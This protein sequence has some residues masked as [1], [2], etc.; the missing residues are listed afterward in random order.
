MSRAFRSESYHKF[1]RSLVQDKVIFNQ[2]M[3][4][5]LALH[6]FNYNH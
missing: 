2:R 6:I 5:R 3:S 1:I 4:R